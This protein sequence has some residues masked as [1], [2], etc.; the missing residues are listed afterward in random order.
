M[1]G[2]SIMKKIYLFL[3][4]FIVVGLACDLSVTVTSAVNTAVPLST[5]TIVPVTETS[6]PVLAS[7]TSAPTTVLPTSTPYAQPSP[8]E[9]TAESTKVTF[10]RLSFELPS[11]V[12][13]G[14]SGKEYPR[15][16]AEDAAYWQKTPGHLQV[17][18]SDYY[19][20]QGK[21]HQPQIYVYPA[22]AYVELVPA[23]FESMHRLRNVM[24]PVAPIT[25]DQLPT[26][27]FFNAAQLFASNVQ[28]ISFQNGSGVRF[29]TEYG[30]Y[31]APV[32]NHE[33][34]YHFQGFTNDGEYYIVAILPITAPVL[35]ETSDAGS[36]LPS[37]GILY[38]FFADPNPETLQGYYG[39]VASL[40]NATSPELFTP[41]IGQ[42]D[43]LIQ[44]MHITP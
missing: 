25:A 44:S 2:N 28:A 42:L 9:S 17:S 1:K 20:L 3:S 15:F 18:L 6:K 4:L 43:A 5:N 32:N 7:S 29:L 23:A 8:I 16:D 30:Q 37:G 35:A 24:N 11:S 13:S 36:P 14:A 26:V 40:L 39:D 33:L 34:F 19:A 31:P 10:G 41:S 38:P 21:L 27:P 22:M 12:A